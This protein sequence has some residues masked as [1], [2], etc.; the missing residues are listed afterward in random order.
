M[1]KE[2]LVCD[3]GCKK[4][5]KSMDMMDNV[6]LTCNPPIQVSVYVCEKCGKRH[7]IHKQESPVQESYHKVFL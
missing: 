5:R 1:K 6:V 4:F 3:C 2:K 7:T